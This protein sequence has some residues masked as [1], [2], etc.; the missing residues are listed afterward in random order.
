MRAYLVYTMRAYVR[1]CGQIR[2]WEYSG[3]GGL[4][5]PLEQCHIEREADPGRGLVRILP[6]SPD[7][8]QNTIQ[9]G[10]TEWFMVPRLI[11]R[12][13]ASYSSLRRFESCTRRKAASLR[14]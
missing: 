8:Q 9:G 13:G 4:P 3:M 14:V 5:L 2:G 1:K 12:G 7:L 10:L 11:P 6:P